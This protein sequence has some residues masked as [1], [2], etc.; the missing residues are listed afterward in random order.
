M[1]DI[2]ES[3]KEPFVAFCQQ[4]YTKT[5]ERISLKPGGAVGYGPRNHPFH[6][7][8]NPPEGVDL[9]IFKISLLSTL[10]DRAFPLI[11]H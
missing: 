1:G 6:F 3:Q 10:Q 4:D 11:S 5:P 7:G 2:E 9:G 8:V